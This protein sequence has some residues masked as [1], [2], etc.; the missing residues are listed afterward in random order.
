VSA[1]D[2]TRME[3]LRW[4]KCEGAPAAVAGGIPHEWRAVGGQGPAGYFGVIFVILLP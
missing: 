3:V 4:K 2:T 1:A